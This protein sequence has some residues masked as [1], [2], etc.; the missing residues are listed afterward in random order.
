MKRF[1]LLFLLVSLMASVANAVWY[2]EGDVDNLWSNP[3]N[4]NDGTV[5]PPA[6]VPHAANEDMRIPK[7]TPA[8]TVDTSDQVGFLFLSRGGSGSGAVVNLNN[9][10]VTLTVTR[11]STELVSACYDDAST[12]TINVSA[13][14][15]VVYR[16]NGLGELRLNRVYN[17]T[18]VGNLNLSGTGIIDVEYLN[19]GDRTAGGNFAA[20]GGTLLVR[21]LINKL[22]WLQMAIQAS[23]W[24]ELLL[25]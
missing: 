7:G 2:W 21:N 14:N 5:S 3:Q 13:G 16:G 8:V 25:K 23:S 6:T 22:V 1:I 17:S 15:L 12:G 4:W 19:K 18:C 20:T 11:A 9:S 10:S 24:A